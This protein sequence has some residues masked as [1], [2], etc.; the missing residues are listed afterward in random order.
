MIRLIL[1]FKATDPWLSLTR[2]KNWE[3]VSVQGEATHCLPLRELISKSFHNCFFLILPQGQELNPT[4]YWVCRLAPVMTQREGHAIKSGQSSSGLELIRIRA[5]ENPEL[6]NSSLDKSHD[7]RCYLQRLNS[8]TFS[9][10][11]STVH[12]RQHTMPSGEN[13]A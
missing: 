4:L 8:N 5:T 13:W 10:G 2:L 12:R 7:T 1:E 3:L 9:E 6:R 11:K